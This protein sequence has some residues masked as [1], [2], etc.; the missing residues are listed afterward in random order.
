MNLLKAVLKEI[1]N[2]NDSNFAA[3]HFSR[4]LSTIGG[5]IYKCESE[6]YKKQINK[7]NLQKFSTFIISETF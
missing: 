3:T 5:T 7:L 4:P 6:N 2:F 1:T